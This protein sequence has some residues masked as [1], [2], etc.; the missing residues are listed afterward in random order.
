MLHAGPVGRVRDISRRIDRVSQPI[1]WRPDREASDMKRFLAAS[2]CLLVCSCSSH[3]VAPTGPSTTAQLSLAHT[4]VL[5]AGFITRGRPEIDINQEAVGIL[6]DE[7]RKTGAVTVIDAP[8]L[9]IDG[10]HQFGDRV[11]WQTLGE[12]H[13]E[14]LIVTGTIT[15]LLA[16]PEI[17]QRGP[18]A[19]YYPMAGRVLEAT[20][21]TIDGRSGQVLSTDKLPTRMRYGFGRFSSGLRLFQQL[22][23]LGMRDWF[24]AI[25]GSRPAVSS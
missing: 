21:V 2:A 20:V 8:P 6:R 7:L 4:R 10:E 15:L 18:R 1:D 9:V 24:D 23:S 25:A 17:V 19:S 16:P 12:E 3:R 22:M 14:P 5:V 11:F 13:R